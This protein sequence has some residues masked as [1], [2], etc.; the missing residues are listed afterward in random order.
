MDSIQRPR[1]LGDRAKDI[2]GA[3]LDDHVTTGYG[4]F[5]GKADKTAILHFSSERA[6][7]VSA[8]EWH[9]SQQGEFLP[10]G[11][12]DLR[13]PNRHSQELVMDILRHGHWVRINGPPSL[14]D[15]VKDNLARAL[16][17][18]SN[19]TAE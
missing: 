13:V 17:Q 4:I 3:E 7:W 6:R 18:Y 12:Y 8:E 10:D 16:R 5:G 19:N 1:V 2:S 15:E 14:C 11:C 9:P